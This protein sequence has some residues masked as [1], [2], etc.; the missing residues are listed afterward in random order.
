MQIHKGILV[1]AADNRGIYPTPGLIDRLPFNGA[2][3]AG[4][5]EEDV[6]IN[7]TANLFSALIAQDYFKPELC[8]GV[9]EPS[10]HVV[11]CSDYNFNAYSPATG[12]FWDT[13]FKADLHNTSNV[14]YAHMPIW[15]DRKLKEWRST[16]G[17]KTPVLGN[18]GPLGGV[19]DP[20]SITN[21]I[22]PPKG[23]WSGNIVYAD[24]SVQFT[25]DFPTIKRSESGGYIIAPECIP[26]SGK[27]P[28]TDAAITFTKEMTAAGPVIQH[29]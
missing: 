21:D 12:S 3:V 25:T 24:N 15:G 20:H 2:K 28:D 1:F 10:S 7:T 19:P 16:A 14:S 22:F 8:I 26:A 13:N 4:R 29:D 5:G 9:T 23:K 6:S 27:I 17:N 11:D 18:R